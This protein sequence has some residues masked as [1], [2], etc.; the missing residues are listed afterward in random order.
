MLRS[1]LALISSLQVGLRIRETVE[2]SLRQAILVAV[3]ALFYMAIILALSKFVDLLDRRY[4][5]A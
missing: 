3:A 1:A 2:R 5:A 4:A